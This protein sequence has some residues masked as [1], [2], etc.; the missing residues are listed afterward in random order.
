MV[1]NKPYAIFMALTFAV[2]NQKGGVGK[3]TTCMNLAGGFARAGYSVLVIDADPQGSALEWRN[4]SEESLLPFELIQLASAS[5]HREIPKLLANSSYE[6]VLIDCPPG[7]AESK[8]HGAVTRSALLAADFVIIPVQPTPMDFLATAIMVP[9]LTDVA[10]FKPEL[11]TLLL[12]SRKPTTASR[13]TRDVRQALLSTLEI[14]GLQMEVLETEI[15]QRTLFAE[16]PGA[17][18]A[19]LD[20]APGTKA[21]EEVELL[22]KELIDKCLTISASG[23]SAA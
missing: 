21:A 18:K 20:Y 17:G 8:G 7:A 11:R 3:T 22:T 13:L 2:C 16:S 15:H 1:P 5:I 19:I 6:L 10:A 4:R 23:V 12:V 14:D 9:L